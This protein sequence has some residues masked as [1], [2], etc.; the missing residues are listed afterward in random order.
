MLKG[1]KRDAEKTAK[2]KRRMEVKGRG[3]WEVTRVK[4]EI[5][6]RPGVSR[7]GDGVGVTTNQA[8][9]KYGGTQ[10]KLGE[11]TEW[12]QQKGRRGNKSITHYGDEG[13][14]PPEIHGNRWEKKKR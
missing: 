10:K 6:V 1:E 9:N 8:T 7:A 4:R 2:R 13:N 14:K 12:G 11:C 5:R 3:P